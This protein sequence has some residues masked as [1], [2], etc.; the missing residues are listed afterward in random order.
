MLRQ[1]D[2]FTIPS[3]TAEEDRFTAGFVLTTE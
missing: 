1:P 3:E 2:V